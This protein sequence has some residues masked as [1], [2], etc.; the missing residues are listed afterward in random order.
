MLDIYRE[1]GKLPVWHL[2]GCETDCMVGNP[3]IPPIADAVVKGFS[4]VDHDLA[5]E[6]MKASA[7]RADRGQEYRFLK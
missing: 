3:G 6:A 2:H 5:F 1:Q 4:G 7:L